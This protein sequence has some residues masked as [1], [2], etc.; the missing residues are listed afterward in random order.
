M[1]LIVFF[2]KRTLHIYYELQALCTINIQNMIYMIVIDN[3]SEMRDICMQCGI[4]VI[5]SKTSLN[6]PT[7][8]PTL[9]GPF[10][11]VDGRFSALE[12]VYS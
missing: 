2:W 10:R 1:A 6:R 9:Y 4:C 12:C 8:G 7:M 11:E 5:Y 3:I